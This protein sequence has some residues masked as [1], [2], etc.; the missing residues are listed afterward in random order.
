VRGDPTS[1]D[2]VHDSLARGADGNRSSQ[3]TVSSSGNPGYFRR[4]AFKMG[5]LLCKSSLRYKQ[6][7]V[8]VAD[9]ALLDIA[10]QRTLDLLPHFIRVGALSKPVRHNTNASTTL[11][12]VPRRSN[13]THRSTRSAQ[14]GLQSE[15]TTCQSRSRDQH[16]YQVAQTSLIPASSAA[17]R[18]LSRKNNSTYK[19]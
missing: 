10:V 3:F 14:L 9:S 11:K 15:C 13:Q 7:E 19:K 6:R 18:G 12:T 1:H 8:A 5:L 2:W 16:Q 17:W 4:E